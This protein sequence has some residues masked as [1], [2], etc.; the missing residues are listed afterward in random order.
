V[1]RWEGDRLAADVGK[2]SAANAVTRPM[3]SLLYPVRSADDY[4][5]IVDGDA[6]VAAC[7]DER[8]LLITPIK[9][10]LHRPAPAPDPS[11]ECSADCVRLYPRKAD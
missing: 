7:D 1:V 10:V 4:S 2:R 6:A 9:A 11:S 5:L 8:G 3:V